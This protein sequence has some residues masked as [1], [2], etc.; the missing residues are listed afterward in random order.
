MLSWLE[1]GYIRVA[2]IAFVVED[3]NRLIALM[4]TPPRPLTLRQTDVPNL[5]DIRSI[6]GKGSKP[7]LLGTNGEKIPIPH[8]LYTILSRIVSELATG[9]T[10]SVI[11]VRQELT[12]KK[13][14]DLLGVS[15]QFLVRLL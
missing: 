3:R 1:M 8:I 6:L 4:N 13:A 7:S 11:P 10:V 12:T 9:Q 2:L 14:A 5:Q 15:R